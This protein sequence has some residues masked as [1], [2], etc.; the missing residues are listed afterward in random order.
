VIPVIFNLGPIP[1]NS[2]GL[3][4][5][6]CFM[7]AWRRLVLSLEAAGENPDIAEKMVVTG[8]ISGIIG[9]RVNYIISNFSEFLKD[10]AAMIFTGAGFVFYGG[11]IIAFVSICIFVKMRGKSLSQYADLAAPCLA[12]GYGIGRIGCHLS[13]DGDYGK[14]TD[15]ILGFSYSLG[16]SPTPRG[17]LVHPTPIYESLL[18]FLLCGVLLELQK[19]KVFSKNG[20]LFGLYILCSSVFRYFIEDLRIEPITKYGITEAQV[21]SLVLIVPALLLTLM[22]ASRKRM[23]D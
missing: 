17:V 18:A 11:F 14:R 5:V 3:M 15:S 8:A 10:P 6:F 1:I 12:I 21:T 22:G 20:Q 7:G 4:M 2:F 23:G 16:V 9:S 19:R 13:G